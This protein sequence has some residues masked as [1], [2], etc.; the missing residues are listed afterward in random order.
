VLFGAW[1]EIQNEK[2]LKKRLR[3]VGYDEIFDTKDYISADSPMAIALMNKQVGDD[4]I[5]KTGAGE[6]VWR[7]NK[8]EY[9]K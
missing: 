1:V 8:I 5:V 9:Q 4:A 3:I 6:F 2:G 7:I